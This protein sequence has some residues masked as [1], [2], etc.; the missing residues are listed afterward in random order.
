[1][2]HHPA[3]ATSGYYHYEAAIGATRSGGQHKD[4]MLSAAA[5]ILAERPQSKVSGPLAKELKE[6]MR[7]AP[8]GEDLTECQNCGEIRPE[9]DLDEID[10]LLAR[11]SP[12]DIVPIGQC[13]E[14]GALC[15]PVKRAN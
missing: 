1:M 11:I 9:R 10:N 12:G 5:A 8:S 15:Q 4:G 6:L 3:P 2:T 13:P 7:P 14:C